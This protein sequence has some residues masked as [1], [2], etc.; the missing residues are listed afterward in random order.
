MI[1]EIKDD[2][3]LKLASYYI[4]GMASY[5]HQNFTRSL[6]D[7]AISWSEYVDALC[8]RFRGQKDPLKE[9]MELRKLGTWKLVSR[10][11][12]YYGIEL[13]LSALVFFIRGLG[14]R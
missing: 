14:W 1:E 12:T 10:T 7:K 8:S 13:R 6:G 9:L 2:N 3:K 5:W 11:S 4:D